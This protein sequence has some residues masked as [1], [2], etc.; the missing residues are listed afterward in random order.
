[1]TTNPQQQTSVGRRSATLSGQ[2]VTLD[3]LPQALNATHANEAH[4]DK[5][6]IRASNGSRKAEQEGTAITSV[7]TSHN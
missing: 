4:D 1:M 2:A 5:L 3:S 7:L 6:H